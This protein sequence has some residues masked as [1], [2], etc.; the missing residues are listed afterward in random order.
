MVGATQEKEAS[1]GGS[2]AAGPLVSVVIVVYNALPH[3]PALAAA[4]ARQ[5]YP[6]VE[7]IVVDNASTDGSVAF[8]ADAMPD[9]A[10]IRLPTNG[11]YAA[12]N[13]AAL[14]YCHGEYLALLNPDTE[15]EPG[16]LAA[17][18]AALERDPSVGLATAKVVLANDRT[19]INTCGNDVHLAGF[20]TCRGLGAPATTYTEAVDV[21][22]VSG[23]AF[24][25]RRELMDRL[26]GFDE[27]FF[28]YVEDTDLSWRALLLGARCRFVPESVV[29]HRYTLT[30]S[31]R[32]T[33][34]LER[35]RLQM[36]LKCYRGRSLLMLLPALAL[37]EFSAWIYA[38]LHG[39]EYLRA[40]AASLG[41]I[42][43]HRHEIR[44]RRR[45]V[46]ATRKVGDRAILT[47]ATPR[48][49]IALVQA[50]FLG[51]VADGATRMPCALSRRVALALTR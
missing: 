15:P 5:T 3:L 49:P 26:G 10:L 42:V 45:Q 19:T 29:A 16:W 28:M 40:K 37:G 23:A 14:P 44:A 39:P 35:N 24:L 18:V 11:G 48:L 1:A 27:S 31:A 30:L 47:L 22:A 50:G 32:K 46:Q 43:Q 8:I 34:Y 7:F 17:L 36:L 21:A 38:A 41:W 51:R 25:I 2:D 20:A 33:G 13:N 12:G 6:H 4:L 9:A